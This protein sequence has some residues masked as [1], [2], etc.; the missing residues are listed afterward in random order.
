MML[1][2]TQLDSKLL[3]KERA[4]WFRASS[5]W[6]ISSSPEHMRSHDCEHVQQLDPGFKAGSP[7]FVVFT[8]IWFPEPWGCCSQ[9]RQRKVR[10]T[11]TSPKR[12]TIIPRRFQILKAT[13]RVTDTAVDIIVLAC[14]AWLSIP[15]PF[16]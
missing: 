6:A 2:Q 4:P 1:K 12:V 8:Q 15:G 5:Y 7:R 16:N 9:R 14:G 11:T 13:G 10:G 3:K